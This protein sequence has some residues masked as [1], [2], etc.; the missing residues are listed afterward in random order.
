MTVLMFQPRFAEPI[1]SGRKCQTIR[2]ARKRPIRI[3]EALSLRRWQGRAYWSPQV[4]LASVRCSALFEIEVGLD[5]VLI[6]GSEVSDLDEF[7][8]GDGFQSWVE[9]KSYFLSGS[10]G[11]PFSGVLIQWDPTACE[12]QQNL[13]K[14]QVS[15]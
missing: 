3:G 14:V 7:A 5:G 1:Q 6:A 8:L 2:P 10:Y 9:M 12:D 13:F 4:E 11:L 15:Q